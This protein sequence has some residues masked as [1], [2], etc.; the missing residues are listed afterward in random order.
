MSVLQLLLFLGSRQTQFGLNCA[1]SVLR[2][3][4][5]IGYI[6]YIGYKLAASG[7]GRSGALLRVDLGAV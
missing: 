2:V 5:G 1:N 3:D 6:G 4:L 7:L